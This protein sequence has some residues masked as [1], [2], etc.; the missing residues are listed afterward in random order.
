MNKKVISLYVKFIGTLFSFYDAVDNFIVI[1]IFSFG[2]L[3]DIGI[4][5][6]LVIGMR[7]NN[8][9]MVQ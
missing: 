3:P 7:K 1:D 8:S 5:F 4:L 2:V 9:F 6:Y